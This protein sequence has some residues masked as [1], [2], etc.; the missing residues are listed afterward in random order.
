MAGIKES[1][2]A[3][4]LHVVS[5]VQK[6]SQTEFFEILIYILKRRVNISNH[7]YLKR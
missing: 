7:K 6:Q 2:Q 4:T 5:S 3:L 1:D